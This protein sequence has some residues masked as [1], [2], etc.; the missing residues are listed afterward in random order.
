MSGAPERFISSRENGLTEAGSE[1]VLGYMAS[2]APDLAAEAL[3]ALRDYAAE[4][5][6]A[7]DASYWLKDPEA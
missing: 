4:E 5:G 2:K 1:F 7:L 6:H 3:K